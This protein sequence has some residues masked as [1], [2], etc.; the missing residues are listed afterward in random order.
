MINLD[1]RNV[2]EAIDAAKQLEILSQW[3]ILFKEAREV[4]LEL[5]IPKNYK[6]KGNETS[7]STPTNIVI[8]GMGGSAIAGDYLFH[9]LKEELSIPVLVNRDYNLPSFVSETSLVVCVSYSGNT[10]ETISC[11]KNGLEKSSMIIT[12]SSGG[13]LEKLS[14]TVG[15]PH[16]KIREGIPPRSGLPLIYTA[17]LTILEKLGLIENMDA[18]IKET[19]EVLEKLSKEYSI[20]QRTDEN[21]PKNIAYGLYNTIPVFVG[22]TF[23]SPIANRAKCELNEN[24]KLLAISEVIPEQNHNGIVAWDNPSKAMNDVAVVLFR[25]KKESPSIKIR[26]DEFKKQVEKKTEKVLEIYPEGKS[27]LTQQISSTY[28]IDLA[29]I[30]LGILYEV[31]PS[32]TPSIDSLKEVLKKKTNLPDRLEKDIL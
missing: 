21:L 5:K 20:E 23:L 18:S 16:I 12:V 28:L 30:Y 4:S 15:I 13:L 25:D 7:Y 1:D 29:S 26:I 31:D 6:W 19:I 11:F 22:H 3:H 2:V 9:L 10:E 27:K 17:L 24:S 8:C 32:V 14:T